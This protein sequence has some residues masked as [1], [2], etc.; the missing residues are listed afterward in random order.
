MNH[1]P[2]AVSLIARP[3]L[4]VICFGA[5]VSAVEEVLPPAVSEFEQALK[6]I[7]K[8]RI[9]Q[10]REVAGDDQYLLMGA[11]I[12]AESA[13]SRDIRH[14]CIQRFPETE[15]YFLGHELTQLQMD[16]ESLDRIRTVAE[17]LTIIDPKNALG[18]YYLAALAAQNNEE[19]TLQERLAVILNCQRFTAYADE[20]LNAH[21]ATTEKL[22]VPFFPVRKLYVI[23]ALGVGFF[24]PHAIVRDHLV[25]QAD[26]LA[27][28]GR[29]DVATAKYQDALFVV[30]QVLTARP[31]LM[32]TEQ[33]HDQSVSRIM[34]RMAKVYDQAGQHVRAESC[35]QTARAHDRHY[36]WMKQL[37]VRKN[38]L[39]RLAYCNHLNAMDLDYLDNFAEQYRRLGSE[40][41][42][43]ESAPDLSWLAVPPTHY[44]TEWNW[45]TGRPKE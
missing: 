25:E 32:I 31:K 15:K 42:A 45:R 17:R 1:K 26:K 5:T 30:D 43:I 22:D 38:P 13:L 35:R 12:L 44:P 16:D 18:H 28:E 23:K 27:R 29:I 21:F 33:Y 9:N 7:S 3:L 41:D 14:D 19:D 37:F 40:V 2:L 34:G 11:A 4:V 24:V 39:H 10:L 20:Y 8:E 6:P 36:V